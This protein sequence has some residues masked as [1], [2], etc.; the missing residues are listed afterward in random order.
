M[1]EYCPKL[2]SFSTKSGSLY[3]GYRDRERQR[4]G[5]IDK[6]KFSVPAGSI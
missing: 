4:L 5:P 3:K 6:K 1:H 2:L